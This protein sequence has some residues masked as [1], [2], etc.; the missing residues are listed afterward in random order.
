M[1]CKGLFYGWLVGWID[2]VLFFFFCGF[3]SFPYSSSSCSFFM[4]YG[5]SQECYVR[6][7]LGGGDVV[8]V[9][10]LFVRVLS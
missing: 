8:C 2:R 4:R 10:R 1:A 5:Y 7:C 3:F 9:F 6:V